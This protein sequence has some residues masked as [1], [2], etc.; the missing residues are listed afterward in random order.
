M[1]SWRICGPRKKQLNPHDHRTLVSA[2]PDQ[3]CGFCPIEAELKADD[4][5]VLQT[6]DLSTQ[7]ETALLKHVVRGLE[8]KRINLELFSEPASRSRGVLCVS[9]FLVEKHANEKTQEEELTWE[10]KVRSGARCTLDS[11]SMMLVRVMA[12]SLTFSVVRTPVR[13]ACTSR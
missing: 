10:T 12:P 3:A 11:R 2:L 4:H 6:A 13:A 7:G 5:I 1:R 8:L 9:Y